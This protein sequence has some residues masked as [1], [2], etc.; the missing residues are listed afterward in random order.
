MVDA[1]SAALFGRGSGGTA[2][3]QL[4]AQQLNSLSGKDTSSPAK[5]AAV[6]V[7]KP[8]TTVA[9]GPF[10][11]VEDTAVT[12]TKVKLVANDTDPNPGDV[13]TVNSVGNPTHGTVTLNKTNGSVTFTP[14]TNY[15]G[16]ASFTYNVKDASGAKA[17]N[18]AK[19]TLT[20]TGVNDAPVA[21]ADSATVSED[22]V[23]IL[24]ANELVGNDTDP[25]KPYGDVLKVNSVG[26]PTHGTVTLNK[27]NGSVTFT[28]ETNYNGAAS[29]TYNVKDASGKTSANTATVTMTVKTN[30]APIAVN[31]TA[32]AVKNVARTLTAAQLLG[33]DTDPDKP[34]GD[35]LKVNSVG[36]ATH[37]TVKLN[38]DGSVTFTPTANYTGAASFIYRVKDAAGNTSAKTAKVSLTVKADQAPTAAPDTATAAEDV[39]RTL[40]AAQLVGNDT[41]PNEADGDTLKVNSVG[42]ATH[43]TVKLNTD[44]SVTFTPTANYTG[45][46]SFIY[47]V[48]DAAGNTS[49]NTAKV[50][51][52]VTPVNDAPTAVND[53]TT[54]TK[55]VTRTLTATQ[56]VGNDTDPDKPY[57]DTLKVNSVAGATH[58]VVK[59]NANGTVTFTPTANYTGPASFNYKVQDASGTTSANTATVSVTVKASGLNVIGSVTIADDNGADTAQVSADGTRAVLTTSHPGGILATD[60]RVM[61][62]VTTVDPKTG[63]Q[64]GDS[65]NFMATVN[66][67]WGPAQIN[68]TGTRALLMVGSSDATQKAVTEVA[69]INTTTGQQIGTTATLPGSSTPAVFSADG[70]RALVTS[71]VNDATGGY[72]TGV[73]VINTTTGQQI[74]TT[75]T[76][77]GS[78][79]GNPAVFSTDGARALLT[80]Y[81]HD[82]TYTNTTRVAVI[83]T[84]TGQQVGTTVSLPNNSQNNPALFNAK[85]TRALLT[86]YTYDTTTTTTRVAV[87]NT[88][89]GTLIGTPNLVGAPV[90]SAQFSADGTRALLTTTGNDANYAYGT[91]FMVINTVTGAQVGTTL[92]V[93]GYSTASAEISGDGSHALMTVTGYD[94]TTFANV[95]QVSLIN[96]ATDAQIGATVTLAGTPLASAQFSADGSRAIV[97]TKGSSNGATTRF[98][99]INTTTGAQIGAT[100]IVTGYTSDPGTFSA[101][102]TH[103]LLTTYDN[104]GGANTI[105]VAVI[106]TT[107]GIQG[108]TTLSFTG[109]LV[110]PAQFTAD[111]TRALLTTYTSNLATTQVAVV[112][113]G[114]GTQTG[115]TITLTGILLAAPQFNTDGTRALL[116]A[117]TYDSTLDQYT[118]RVTLL[119]VTT[120][121]QTGVYTLAG[122]D[123]P[124][125]ARFNP[126]DIHAIVFTGTY[127]P[128]HAHPPVVTTATV[129]QYG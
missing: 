100:L 45:A 83:D 56:L 75:A 91:R 21:V 57:G 15:N 67:G 88:T 97:T 17:A 50:S 47:R 44:G 121:A 118:T 90:G 9:D 32:T 106:N 34:Y 64:I 105:R 114:T 92:T 3:S 98:A 68:A 25:D 122:M 53:T 128:P 48:K 103:A 96:T 19:V 40:T 54:A 58:G 61:I 31:D 89:T 16:A 63:A 11:V 22:T 20:V 74:G 80:T 4:V 2:A 72:S 93:A 27:T 124:G 76:L 24:T 127:D 95:A 109:Q 46:A 78:S 66:D 79:S 104:I 28:P 108:G 60:P 70:T 112:N 129:L 55:N 5:S 84:S 87:I 110:Y 38:T 26:N 36:S 18:T 23:R 7:N 123:A 51:I 94:P 81:T 52:T 14:E 65:F 29:F 41:D 113:T 49:A 73:A 119:N 120:G 59:L 62:V 99:V 111:G 42:S 69:V 107:T 126:D 117:H 33:N 37:G 6:V 13:L 30:T 1:I 35:T 39:A 8:P 85:G 10:S 86:T 43:G 71:V 116:T 115:P 102:G 101:D 77:P 12:L 125:P 82:G